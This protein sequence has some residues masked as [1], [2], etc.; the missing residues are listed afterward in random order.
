MDLRVH[1]RKAFTREFLPAIRDQLRPF[2]KG[3]V[4]IDTN[5]WADCFVAVFLRIDHAV[6]FAFAVHDLPAASKW[7]CE[8]LRRVQLRIL[9]T[10]SSDIEQAPDPVRDRTARASTRAHGR[11]LVL[12]RETLLRL[13]AS[14]V[15]VTSRA[16]SDV[17]EA[18]EHIDSVSH[19]L[20]DTPLKLRTSLGDVVVQ[21]I[22][23]PGIERTYVTTTSA[24]DAVSELVSVLRSDA[25]RLALRDVLEFR[26]LA[27]DMIEEG[28]TEGQIRAEF[29][30]HHAKVLRSLRTRSR[31]AERIAIDVLNLD[32]NGHLTLDHECTD[33]E[34]KQWLP[35]MRVT[36]TEASTIADTH[37]DPRSGVAPYVIWR[38]RTGVP[39]VA[40]ARDIA[41]PKSGED[42]WYYERDNSGLYRAEHVPA[43]YKRHN[44][45]SLTNPAP[46]RTLLCVPVW[47]ILS[48]GGESGVA[49]VVSL[50]STIPNAFDAED[51]AWSEAAAHVLGELYVA[52]YDV[53]EA[54]AGIPHEG[55]TSDGL[56][57]KN[58]SEMAD[59]ARPSG[60]GISLVE[61]VELLSNEPTDGHPV[62][63]LTW[64]HLS[65]LHFGAADLRWRFDQRRVLRAIAADIQ[66][67]SDRHGVPDFIFVTGD[68]AF[69]AAA[70]EYDQ[71]GAW[72]DDLYTKTLS[73]RGK[74]PALRIVP[75][76]HDVDRSSIS[77]AAKEFH[78]SSRER[79][80][81]LDSL[82][83]DATAAGILL[84]KLEQ[85]RQ[86]AKARVPSVEAFDWVEDIAPNELRGSVR[87]A[88]LSTVWV[89]DE[90]D[91]VFS[92]NVTMH[93][94][95]LLLA[96]KQLDAVFG[97]ASAERLTLLL[98]HHP[99]DW[100]HKASRADFERFVQ[101]PTVHLCGHVHSAGAVD[102]R[103]FASADATR[104]SFIAGA[105]HDE[106]ES[107]K[108]HGYSFGAIG[109]DRARG[110]W[111]I[112]WCPRMFADDRSEMVWD[113]LHAGD[114]PPSGLVWSEIDIQW[115]PPRWT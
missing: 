87:L 46:Y 96:R 33:P 108:L 27:D 97:E 95:N 21:P 55:Q 89:S 31:P 76:N 24:E 94:P 74:S 9:I 105:A 58:A 54:A 86:F 112:G 1:E 66:T 25:L 2:E 80:E 38:T 106:P 110:A 60:A 90:L 103:R 93:N 92:K 44:R 63:V 101:G 82:I 40:I 39:G 107:P 4:L 84:E 16:A 70:A 22:A 115:A 100:L 57:L 45:E 17:R 41:H 65:D 19:Q 13:P 32:P 30:I 98:T 49:G 53:L 78:R 56:T 114:Q 59:S 43:M 12:T 69:K 51:C 5:S 102:Q 20:L 34:N 7:E 6:Q 8:P 28:W 88:G 109:Y 91:G 50:T 104:F 10:Q 42:V 75:G 11:A 113:S 83:A 47:C 26:R 111:C 85:Y 37:P 71:A 67:L 62:S 99:P 3:G 29:D 81:L 48:H 77:V 72:L 64:L 52:Y 15:W 23:E 36:I 18:L 73:G 79:S 35:P 68:I 61:N 14:A